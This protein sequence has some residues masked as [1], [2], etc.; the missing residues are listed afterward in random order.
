MLITPEE[1]MSEWKDKTKGEINVSLPGVVEAYDPTTQKARIRPVVRVWY[2]EEDDTAVAIPIPAIPQVPVAFF[3]TGDFA[4]HAPLKAGDIV[5]LLVQDRSIDEFM[6]TGNSDNAP[7]DV[8]RFDWSDAVA[9]PFPPAPT[10]IGELD[11]NNLILGNSSVKLTMTPAGKILIEAGGEELLQLMIDF[12]S[13]CQ[14]AVTGMGVPA[15][16]DPTSVANLLAL[17]N[18]LTAMKA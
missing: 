6:A 11:A 3:R 17:K 4:L 2:Y 14:A 18:S 5:T 12:V 9:L 7:F 16:A 1:V 15:F 10:P 8:R 13:I